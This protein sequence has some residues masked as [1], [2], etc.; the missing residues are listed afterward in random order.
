MAL[1]PDLTHNSCGKRL[2][3]G[4]SANPIRLFKRHHDR[5]KA[6]Q[7]GEHPGTMR[8][9]GQG[10]KCNHRRAGA[11]RQKFLIGGH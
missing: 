2:K 6:L 9:P 3:C 1:S 10:S 8:G 11:I 5:N 4:F 7:I